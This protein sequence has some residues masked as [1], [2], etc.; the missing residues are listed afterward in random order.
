MLTATLYRLGEEVVERVAVMPAPHRGPIPR[1]DGFSAVNAI[2][3]APTT[4]MKRLVQTTTAPPPVDVL[5]PVDVPDVLTPVDVPVG[6]TAPEIP[7]PPPLPAIVMAPPKVPFYKKGW[8]WG[9]IGV[10]ALGL[11]GGILLIRKRRG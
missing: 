11:I 4:I 6:P 1:L 10:G 3:L 2:T 8:Y 5:A 7:P 9:V